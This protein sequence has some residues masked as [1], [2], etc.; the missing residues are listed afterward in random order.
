MVSEESS[1][2]NMVFMRVCLNLVYLMDME[3]LLI[4]TPIITK[5]LFLLMLS[6]KVPKLLKV[7][8]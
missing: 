8:E 1:H 6:K 7:M 2:P 4:N 3:V 5:E